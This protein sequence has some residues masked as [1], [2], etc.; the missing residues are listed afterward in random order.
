MNPRYD[1]ITECIGP[2]NPDGRGWISLFDRAAGVLGST[3][4]G[5]RAGGWL[6]GE[7][8]YYYRD[9]P[10][11]QSSLIMRPS[12]EA[13]E[14]AG[15]EIERAREHVY[16]L[17]S[18]NL[19]GNIY[20]DFDTGSRFTPYLVVGVGAGFTDLDNGRMV[21]RF[22]DPAAFTSIPD[23][24]SNADETRRNLAGT[25]TAVLTTETDTMTAY[26]VLFG[27]DLA[28]SEPVSLSFKGRR[29]R[30]GTF[31]GSGVL[32][33]LRSHPPNYRRVGS[34]PLSYNRTIEGA[35][36]LRSSAS[37]STGGVFRPWPSRGANSSASSRG[38]TT[39]ADST[40]RSDTSRRPTSRNSTMQP[41][42]NPRR[43]GNDSAP[44][45][46]GLLASSGSLVA[47]IQ[48]RREERRTYQTP[49]TPRTK[50]SVEAGQV[51]SPSHA[52]R[53]ILRSTEFTSPMKSILG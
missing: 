23:H 34:L 18:H 51:H 30:Y 31:Q 10:Y 48:R 26:Q 22:L 27:R 14:R 15:G 40:P 17:T 29:V 41:E 16:S 11:D 12:G 2:P 1:E 49:S 36:S 35:S 47:P 38:S 6:R 8:E 20:V 24:W 3:A 37:F 50:Q 25:T 5:Y 33:Q 32:D 28:L 44:G 52:T 21:T 4:I 45:F 13:S 42:A 7:L 43:R 53:P 46:F 19:F 9:S 39:L